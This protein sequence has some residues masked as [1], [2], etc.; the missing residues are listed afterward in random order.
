MLRFTLLET[1]ATTF[2]E[3]YVAIIL[4]QEKLAWTNRTSA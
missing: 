2:Q 3:G 4:I 1:G